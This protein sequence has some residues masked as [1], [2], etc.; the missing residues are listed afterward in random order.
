M[1]GWSVLLLGLG[2]GLRHA[3]D[4]DHLVVVSTL[5]QREPG[6]AR[7]A[8][9]AALWGAGHTAT[10]LGLGLLVVLAELRLPPVFERITEVIVGAML[11]GLGLWHLA[12]S[13]TSTRVSRAPATTHAR[14]VVAGLVH[15]LAGS[16]GIALLAATPIPSRALAV[17]Y[18]G[19]IA[20]GTVVGMVALTVAMARPIGWTMQREGALTLRDAGFCWFHPLVME[21]EQI[22][23]GLFGL[24]RV[25]GPNEPED[26]N[27]RI[28]VL[29]DV[30]LNEDGG[31]YEELDD[32]M[33]MMDREGNV[34]LVNGKTLP[35]LDV[36]PGALTRLRI[37]NVANG[38]F[39]NLA[40]PGHTFR[41]IG[42]DGGLIPK[43]YDAEKLLLS[44]GERHDVVLIAQGRCPRMS[45]PTRTR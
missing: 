6:I 36:H 20:L 41:V 8:R 16:A 27:K 44:P 34:V 37:V 42:T 12:R 28:V 31:F 7:A 45:S 26:D 1:T 35:V 2:L 24:I 39:F 40:L 18:L 9:I 14:P 17:A 30:L 3:T 38:R 19:L 32:D 4:A 15:G 10:F 11:L 23:K 21:P 22:Q 29:G 25:R 5:V 43:P 33:I 13:R